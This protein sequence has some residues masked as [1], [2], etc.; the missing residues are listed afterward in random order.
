M[1]NILYL[2]HDLTDPSVRK[3]V[4]MLQDGGSV[5]TLAGFRREQ[6]PVNNVAGCGVVNLGQTYNGR[7]VQRIWAVI[8]EVIWLKRHRDIFSGADIIIARNLEM[9]ALAVR[10]KSL[11]NS[12][13]AVIYECLDIHRLLLRGDFIGAGFRRL[14]SWLAGKASALITSSP[15]FVREYFNVMSGVQLAVRMVENKVY[16]PGRK[17]PEWTARESGPPWKIGWFGAIRCR[18]SLQILSDV[19]RQSNGK[20]EVIIRGRPA[21]DQFEDFH[22]SVNE[23][24]G[25]RFLG[26]YKNPDDLESI[27]R[28]IHFTWAIDMFEEGLNSSWLLPN[29]LYEGG[30]YASVPIAEESVETGR[31]LK[32]LGIG[33]TLA[34]PKTASLL[35]FFTELTPERYTSLEYAAMQVPRTT[36]SYSTQDCKN[37]V[38]YLMTFSRNT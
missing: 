17:V 34:E 11:G 22:R 2:V 26:A 5:V 33:I 18:K 19:V 30:L 28:N 8:R 31:F 16:D 7:F 37:L 38:E 29:R 32:N 20:V 6:A 14:E 15:A 1:V 27:Y 21:L 36:W 4:Q 9:L 35:A 24:P 25:L 12:A 23:V 13:A 3:R 10:G